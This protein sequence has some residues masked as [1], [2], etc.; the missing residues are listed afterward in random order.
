MKIK[1]KIKQIT[2][3]IQTHKKDSSEH[4]KECD[5]IK[6]AKTALRDMLSQTTDIERTLARFEKN[7][8]KDHELVDFVESLE[9]YQAFFEAVLHTY[10]MTPLLDSAEKRKQI[11]EKILS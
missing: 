6:E 1:D 11:T 2:K 5:I 4:Q 8:Y 9:K 10:K 3:K 7:Q